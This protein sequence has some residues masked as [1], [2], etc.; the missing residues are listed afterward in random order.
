MTFVEGT[1][2]TATGRKKVVTVRSV[3]IK[4]AH[5]SVIDGFLWICTATPIHMYWDR[6]SLSYTI[7]IILSMY[8]ARIQRTGS[9]CAKK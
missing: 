5:Y 6:S 7:G 3:Q 9:D 1:K 8:P 4:V 2:F